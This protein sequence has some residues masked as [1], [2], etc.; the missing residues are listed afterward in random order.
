MVHY[1]DDWL[2]FCAPEEH[3]SL[4][5]RITAD[6]AAAGF[7][8][9]LGKSAG[10]DVPT[11]I[12]DWIGHTIDL[13]AGTVAVLAHHE[14][15]V[16]EMCRAIIALGAHG[17][18]PALQLMR[19][20]GKLAS[21]YITLGVTLRMFTFHL[22]GLAN[23]VKRPRHYVRLSVAAVEEA[24]FWLANFARLNTAPL[25]RPVGMQA[26]DVTT[27]SDAGEPGW[28][29]HTVSGDGRPLAKEDQAL[30]GWKSAERK[31]SSTW[32]ELRCLLNVIKAFVRQLAGKSVLAL[33]D[34]MNLR[35]LWD[36]GGSRIPEHH[37]ML[38]ELWQFCQLHA[39]QLFVQW[40]PR[41]YNDRADYL[42]K[43][44]DRSDW[45]L[46]KRHVRR[47]QRRFGA[48][49]VDLF[50]SHRNNTVPRYFSAFYTPNTAG[51][52]A[53]TQRWGHYSLCWCFPPIGVISA[54]LQYAQ[55][56]RANLI[57]VIP[58][59]PSASWWPRV[60]SA[61]GADWATFVHG[62][63]RLPREP[64]TLVRGTTNEFGTGAPSRHS[65]VALLVRMR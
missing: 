63:E 41:R 59:W 58:D 14:Q 13:R 24:A 31:R 1:I 35:R 2:F 32:R 9:N 64:D 26:V 46:A 38:V 49:D 53:F 43:F 3:A 12:V 65:F 56:E 37:A 45:R 15:H 8:V 10:L 4:V 44:E 17:M 61:D 40:I 11:Y 21:A 20:T 55:A 33:V 19:L 29:G 16:L 7:I 36:R 62:A 54:V 47:L 48:C 34:A 22:N 60:R 5:A 6:I 42:S 52:D 23:S 39:I 30:G 28:G 51:V 50:A 27:A 18:L 57:L 25:W